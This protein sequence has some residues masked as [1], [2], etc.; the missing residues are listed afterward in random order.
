MDEIKQQQESFIQNAKSF[1]LDN[2]IIN[3]EIINDLIWAGFFAHKSV[4]NVEIG[5]DEKNKK[6]YFYLYFNWFQKLT[7][8]V[9]KL[10]QKL[11]EFVT[12]GLKTWT[13]EVIK[14]NYVQKPQEQGFMAV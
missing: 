12:S 5:I 8:S 2:E 11:N 4:Q 14:E 3:D 9:E 7:V 10:K 1:L 6:V 13:V